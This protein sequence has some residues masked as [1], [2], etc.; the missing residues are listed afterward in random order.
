M[1]ETDRESVC[2]CVC[3]RARECVWELNDFACVSSV[4]DKRRY[5]KEKEWI[6]KGHYTTKQGPFEPITSLAVSHAT[7]VELHQQY[8]G[9]IE[10]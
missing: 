3:V 6:G 5:L 7:N 10:G 1:L 4:Y 8:F 2:V 9:A